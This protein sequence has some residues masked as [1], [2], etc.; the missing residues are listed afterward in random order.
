[1]PAPV[2]SQKQS[3]LDFDYHMNVLSAGAVGGGITYAD[4][5]IAS[6]SG[7]SQTLSAANPAR[8][9]LLFK[10]GASLAAINI[11]GGTA[12]IGTAGTYTVPAGATM[13]VRTS[14]AVTVIATA[15]TPYT[16]TET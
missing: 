9:T 1:M 12:A 14:N 8:K 15:S 2:V 11:L 13:R 3:D 16:A 6:L 7:V 5:T 4:E 10:N